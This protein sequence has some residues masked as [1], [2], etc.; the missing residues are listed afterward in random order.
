MSG[1]PFVIAADDAE[2]QR[3]SSGM[4]IQAFLGSLVEPTRDLAR[5]PISNFRVG[6]VGLGSSGRVFRGVN[7]EFPGLP[8][9]HSVHAEQFLVANLAQHGEISIEFLA[10]S[11]APCG[12]CRQFLQ[13][14]RGAKDL[15]LFIVDGENSETQLL[16]R[17]LP[18][19]FG[20][21]D[22]LAQD[23]DFPLLLEPRN[24]GLVLEGLDH[25]CYRG[26]EED[27]LD[28]SG[29]EDARLRD[30]ALEAANKSYAPY[31]GSPSGVAIFTRNAR[32]FSGSYCESAAFNPSL[33][34]LQAAIVAFVANGG[35]GYQDIV[36]AVLVETKNSSVQQAPTT[37]MALDQISPRCPLHVYYAGSPSKD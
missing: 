33:P 30:A 13:E 19:R 6:A 32:V 20:P 26:R 14:L 15:E 28:L 11:A 3:S 1:T 35:G 10:V 23:L 16:S 5:P 34:P 25:K 4:S 9:H 36:C 29:L 8:L 31:T 17:F 7:L 24:N 37:R 27:G 2:Q 21:D 12:H 18:H 22:L